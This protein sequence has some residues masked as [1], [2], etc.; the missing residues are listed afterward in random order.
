MNTKYEGNWHQ[1]RKQGIGKMIFLSTND[2]YDGEWKEDIMEG[3]GQFT[4]HDGSIFI[5]FFN[6]GLKTEGIFRFKNGNEYS[7]GF[8]DERRH[9]QG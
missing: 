5:G 4:F 7:G 3:K 2:Q 9:G 1:G 6:D 8:K